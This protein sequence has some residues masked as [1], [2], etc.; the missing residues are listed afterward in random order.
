MPNAGWRP[1]DVN[2][3]HAQMFYGCYTPSTQVHD[4]ERTEAVISYR[5]KK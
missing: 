4:T 1:D 5:P 2:Y 3:I